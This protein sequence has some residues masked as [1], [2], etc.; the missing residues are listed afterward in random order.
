[1]VVI[2]ESSKLHLSIA[3]VCLCIIALVGV[4]GN[5][6]VL[7]A[8]VTSRKLQTKINCFIASLAVCDLLS[9]LTLPGQ[10]VVISN[11]I[12]HDITVSSTVLKLIFSA[13]NVVCI[14]CSIL[15]LAVIALERVIVI[16]RPRELYR[17]VFSSRNI[18]IVIVFTW[19]FPPLAIVLIDVPKLDSIDHY[20]NAHTCMVND[21]DNKLH[22]YD[23]IAFIN[24]NSAM[25]IVMICYLKIYLHVKRHRRSLGKRE[26][27]RSKPKPSSSVL[28][29]SNVATCSSTD[30]PLADVTRSLNER[31]L[32][33]TTDNFTTAIQCNNLSSENIRIR[34]LESTRSDDLV[35]STITSTRVA[36]FDT[37]PSHSSVEPYESNNTNE[38]NMSQTD[39]YRHDK[40]DQSYLQVPPSSLVKNN[41]SHDNMNVITE[42]PEAVRR[43]LD[44]KSASTNAADL[45]D[46]IKDETVLPNMPFPI[47][48][49]APSTSSISRI[50]PNTI[51]GT[52]NKPTPSTRSLQVR[53]T[54]S[55]TRACSFASAERCRVPMNRRSRQRDKDEMAIT[56]NLL[57]VVFVSYLCIMPEMGCL[58]VRFVHGPVCACLYSFTILVCNHCIN[59]IVYAYRHPIFKPVLR[60][61]LRRRLSDIPEPSP[62]LRRF[63]ARNQ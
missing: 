35:I 62:W 54:L 63:M 39:S 48:V 16:T 44:S 20:I 42:C 8:I 50:P 24:T 45:L 36:V 29:I 27:H 57:M 51:Q 2:S 10:I 4:I 56:K 11:M 31:D 19:T 49:D 6:L 40:N 14:S 58:F 41:H 9:S 13:F 21:G 55:G 12:K 47:L 52:P 61:L 18:A 59:P 7:G 53:G 46:D 32:S 15:T 60:C 3:V 1:M 37:N 43:D 22:I 34:S 5:C 30:P 17:R 33:E 25:V 38:I 23:I 26:T 28:T